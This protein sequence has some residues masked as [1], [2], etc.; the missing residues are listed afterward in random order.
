MVAVTRKSFT[1][2]CTRTGGWW[3]ISVPDADGLWTQS[4]RLDQVEEMARDAIGAVM[5]LD[6]DQIEVQL[7][8]EL[9]DPVLR[10]AVAN[11]RHL[12]AEAERLQHEASVQMSE[13]VHLLRDK[14]DLSMRD[15]AVLL[16]VSHQRVGQLARH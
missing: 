9:E 10:E 15:V 3:A 1:A 6:D 4:K 12:R 2:H 5:D 13:A 11:V 16:G 14:A 7:E 8:V